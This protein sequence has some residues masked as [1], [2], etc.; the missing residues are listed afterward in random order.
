MKDLRKFYINGEWV[1]PEA[2]EEMDIIN[3]ATESPIGTITLGS[4]A[5]VG[6]AT[7]NAIATPIATIVVSAITYFQSR[8]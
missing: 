1:D 7:A 8:I 2:S 5:D 3:P 6:R 4:A